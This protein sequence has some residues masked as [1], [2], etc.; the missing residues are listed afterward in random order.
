MLR[1]FLGMRV[2]G[3]GNAFGSQ[4]MGRPIIEL[5]R[6]RKVV[7]SCSIGGGGVGVLRDK[8]ILIVVS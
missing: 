3:L 6:K 8:L 7:V 2:H 5:I 1:P 4:C